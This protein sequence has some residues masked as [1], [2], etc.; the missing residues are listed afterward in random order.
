[1]VF[2]ENTIDIQVE[3]WKANPEFF[4]YQKTPD[5]DSRSF[6][7]LFLYMC[8][9]VESDCSNHFESAYSITIAGIFQN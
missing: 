4:Y 5:F 1:M 6:Y 9:Y 3:L 7:F 2:I 8:L